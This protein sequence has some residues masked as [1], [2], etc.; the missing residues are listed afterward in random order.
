MTTATT[1]DSGHPDQVDFAG[2][3]R[4]LIDNTWVDAQSGNT[5]ATDNPTTGERLADVAQAEAADV[6]AAVRAARAAFDDG[7]WPQMSPAERGVYL[8]RFAELIDGH[9]EELAQLETLD[10]G[11]TI[12]MARGMVAGAAET[13]VHFAGAAHAIHGVTPQ[14]DSGALNYSLRDPI[15]VVGSIVPW[16]AP[17]TNASWKLGPALAAGNTIV[18][19]PAELTPLTAL[20]LG[21]LALLADFP[22]GVLNVLPGLG[23][24]AGAAL[25]DHAGVNKVSF[26]G[27]TEVGKQILRASI[28]Q[29][30]H[31]SLELGGKSPNI[32]FADADLEKATAVAVAAFTTLS[33]QICTAGSRLFVQREIYAEV[34]EAISTRVNGLTVGDPLD[35]ATDVGPLVSRVQ[36]DRVAGYLMSGKESGA[37]SSAGGSVPD[38]P[39]FF[40]EPTVFSD[41]T[42]TMAIAQE[43][44]FGPVVSVI[45]FDDEDEV[46]RMANDTR[47]GLAAALWTR[48]LGRAHRVARRIQ[49]GTVWVNSWGAL[50]PTLPFGGYKQSGLGREFGLDWYHAY[51]ENKAVYVSL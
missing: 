14:S 19:K 40:V 3:T 41:V 18:L 12:G 17:I 23:T 35:A 28:D 50:D 1:H 13:L 4:L 15:G 9:A 42:Q 46:V 11:M 25:A 7:P 49:A 44:I 6:D 51:T 48:D 45:A 20:R 33:G 10:S 39:G 24:G 47:Y 43:E 37:T 27:S 22:S 2:Q 38:R 29:L 36:R 30:K 8:R 26:T 5:F 21:E 34:V 16:N 32:I 31:I